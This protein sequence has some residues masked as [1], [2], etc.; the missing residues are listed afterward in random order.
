MLY[1]LA[2]SFFPKSEASAPDDPVISITYGDATD[3]YHPNWHSA[4]FVRVPTASDELFALP[5][6]RPSEV[7]EEQ[8]ETKKRKMRDGKQKDIGSLLDSFV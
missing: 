8:V 1:D 5:V 6:K 4:W 7:T 2:N 3:R